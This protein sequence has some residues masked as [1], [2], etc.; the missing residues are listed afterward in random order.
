MFHLFVSFH[1]FIEINL[2][3]ALQ[4]LLQSILI[5]RKY[6]FL[7]YFNKRHICQY[8]MW[9]WKNIFIFNMWK[10]PCMMT[11]FMILNFL[12]LPLKTR[13][14]CFVCNRLYKYV[15]FFGLMCILFESCMYKGQEEKMW[16]HAMSLVMNLMTPCSWFF[17]IWPHITFLLPHCHLHSLKGVT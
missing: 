9:V 7:P 10:Q 5:S 6:F 17:Y 13:L 11:L 1:A 14:F 12:L 2:C 15:W 8:K 3:L 16:K 4:E